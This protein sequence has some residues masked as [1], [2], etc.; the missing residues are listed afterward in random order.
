MDEGD[1]VDE[2]DE[3]LNTLR[4]ERSDEIEAAENAENEDLEEDEILDTKE[5]R[6][7]KERNDL[8]E[9]LGMV[10]P[11]KEERT[12]KEKVRTTFGTI[13]VGSPEHSERLYG[14]EQVFGSVHLGE[15]ALLHSR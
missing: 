14:V 15:R 1:I 4:T 9:F 6:V 2:D 10:D 3:A 11:D 12:E 7:L 8:R 13:T 5:D